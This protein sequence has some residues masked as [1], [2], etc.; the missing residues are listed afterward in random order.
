MDS[1]LAKRFKVF[2]R[3]S[4]SLSSTLI[5]GGGLAAMVAAATRISA[6]LA[7]FFAAFAPISYA[8]LLF[9][10]SVADWTGGLLLIGLVAMY[11]RQWKDYGDL[12]L[13]GYLEAYV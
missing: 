6:D 10:D 12:E 13:Y 1:R 7:S 5:R 11:D 3:E 4:F 9:R 8:V 2:S